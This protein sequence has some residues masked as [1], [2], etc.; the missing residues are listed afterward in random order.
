MDVI[1][2]VAQVGGSDG[3]GNGSDFDCAVAAG[4]ADDFLLPAAPQPDNLGALVAALLRDLAAAYRE[5]MWPALVGP[6]DA[7]QRL[8]RALDALFGVIGAHLPC[9][10]PRT[11]SSTG[12]RR[13][14]S[15][16]VS[17]SPTCSRTASGV[18]HSRRPAATRGS[19]AAV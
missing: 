8:K 7:R 4:G 14:A 6:G 11:R 13:P 5:A 16:P 3:V 15:I 19:G 12:P 10:S 18:G 9:C 1:R 17:R 2:G